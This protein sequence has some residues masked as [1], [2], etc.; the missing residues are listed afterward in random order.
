[1]ATE[2][3][4]SL[5]SFLAGLSIG[6]IAGVLYAPHAGSETRK[7]LQSNVEEA[8]EFV[9]D[10]ATRARQQAIEWGARNRNILNQQRQRFLSPADGM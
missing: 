7:A 1:M 3:E 5:V 8:W 6:A 4:R 10:R 2:D 9:R